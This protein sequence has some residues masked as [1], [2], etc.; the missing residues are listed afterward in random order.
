MMSFLYLIATAAIIHGTL[1]LF[2]RPYFEWLDKTLWDSE[3][4][5]NHEA[6]VINRYVQGVS[7]AGGGIVA[8]LIFWYLRGS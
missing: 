6:Y 5:S 1:M 8:L 2:Y 3:S 7:A 4:K